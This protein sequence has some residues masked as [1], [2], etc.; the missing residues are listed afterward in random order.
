[1]IMDCE[2]CIED[3]TAFIDGE[4][5]AADA[6][7]VKSHLGICASCADELRSLK[8][9]AEFIE[10]HRNDLKLRAESW[11]LVRARISAEDSLSKSF[12][13][14]RYLAFSRFRMAMAG[15]VLVAGFALGYM[16]YQQIQKKSLDKYIS[17]YIQEREARRRPQSILAN[18]EANPQVEVPYAD[19][20]FIEV[21]AAPADN[22]FR[23]E[24]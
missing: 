11:N 6:E 21:K 5:C 7:R 18:T 3:M 23:S 9:A 24:D 16:Q 1:M 22:P 17:Q 19:N 4:L 15:L 8:E 12:S 13:P 2:Q 14:F 20:P 10:S